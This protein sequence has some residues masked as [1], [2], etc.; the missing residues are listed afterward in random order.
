MGNRKVYFA[1]WRRKNKKIIAKKLAII[2]AF[3]NRVAIKKRLKAR[4]KRDKSIVRDFI[5]GITY[6]KI[7]NKHN[8]SLERC[9]QILMVWF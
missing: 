2:Y 9:R 6:F 5:K 7:K 4:K 8:I 3:K 1:N